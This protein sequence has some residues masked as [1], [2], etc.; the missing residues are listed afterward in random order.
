[1]ASIW[2]KAFLAKGT[3]RAKSAYSKNISEARCLKPSKCG[4]ENKKWN[5][6]EQGDET[7]ELSGENICNNFN[8]QNIDIHKKS[9][10]IK[11][12]K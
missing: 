6:A 5:K 12:R 1:M 9:P 10:N 3:A 4:G 11:V 2:G 7:S 8:K